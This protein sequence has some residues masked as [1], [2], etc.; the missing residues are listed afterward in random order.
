MITMN[1]RSTSSCQVKMFYASA[2][3]KT[4]FNTSNANNITI[5]VILPGKKIQTSS[6]DFSLMTTK[7]G[8]GVD[9]SE[10]LKIM[11]SLDGRSADE[12]YREALKKK[13]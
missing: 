9:R 12:F 13:K 10:H 4:S 2:R 11:S 1:K 7:T 5:S 6:K 3:L 8:R